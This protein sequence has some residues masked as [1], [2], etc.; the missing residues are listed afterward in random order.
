MEYL[1]PTFITLI[2]C[3]IGSFLNVVIYRGPVQWGLV[4]HS[5][6][7]NL[8]FPASH[9]PSCSAP[10]KAIHL[11]PI[12]SYFLLRGR[13]G[14]CG[15]KISAQ[16]PVV[17]ILTASVAL[18]SYSVFGAELPALIL[19][20]LFCLLICLSFIDFQTTFLP[21]ALT[22]PFLAIAL[23]GNWMEIFTTFQSAL[24]GA[25]AGF[26][27]FWL[28][29]EIYFRLKGIDGLGMGDAK[30]LAGLGA[31]LGWAALPV[32]VLISSLVGL[33]FV[34][35]INFQAQ[36]KKIS[37]QAIPFG[38]SLIIGSISVFLLIQFDLFPL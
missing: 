23:I 10:L 33:C 16:Y 7:L 22:L 29:G 13:C 28:I 14:N 36:D 32:I 6:K 8:A 12:V 24:I 30:L 18:F 4:E 11:I 26:L 20:V 35:A 31:W 3:I 27:V 9:C 34:A 19:F 38:P 5:K 25:G 37:E 15:A 21:D 1:F 17:E 2:G